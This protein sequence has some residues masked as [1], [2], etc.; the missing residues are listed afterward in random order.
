MLDA[1]DEYLGVRGGQV[2]ACVVPPISPIRR[3]FRSYKNFGRCVG[4][5][6]H[7]EVGL[8]LTLPLDI[9]LCPVINFKKMNQP[10]AKLRMLRTGKDAF[11][12]HNRK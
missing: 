11:W 9:L 3:N 5:D 4:E 10:F 2:L 1:F 6:V 7:L 8:F 12:R